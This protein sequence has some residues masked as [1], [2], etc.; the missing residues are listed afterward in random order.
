MGYNALILIP[1]RHLDAISVDREFGQRVV[2][3]CLACAN[4]RIP[5]EEP[6]TLRFSDYAEAVG[7]D[8][9]WDL[10]WA[11][12]THSS[13]AV[14]TPV[15]GGEARSLHRG[16]RDPEAAAALSEAFGE[17]SEAIARGAMA[18][19]PAHGDA[20][21]GLTAACFMH[22]GLSCISR[23]AGFGGALADRIRRYAR[24]I[25][26][27]AVS[28]RPGLKVSGSVPSLNHGNPVE[29]GG[30]IPE[31]GRAIAVTGGNC[32]R[33]LRPCPW[34]SFGM[35]PD[36]DGAPH[37]R[38]LWQEDLEAVA[39]LLRGMGMTPSPSGRKSGRRCGAKRPDS[40][41]G[42]ADPSTPSPA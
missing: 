23:D 16:S 36:E 6:A 3:F 11:G 27:I 33:I 5:G 19:E 9:A 8:C 13:H 29:I 40:G 35:S 20:G 32:T 10:I 34:Q 1:N 41:V 14:V 38:R 21:S 4:H 12:C 39:G 31:G 7:H 37:I 25:T 2:E 42:G 28:R 17:L 26:E 15:F 22:D 30:I 18:P 24:G